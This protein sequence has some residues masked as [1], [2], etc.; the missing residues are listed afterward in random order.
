M[1]GAA[2]GGR[3][4]PRGPPGRGASA[5]LAKAVGAFRTDAAPPAR[6]RAGDGAP[7]LQKRFA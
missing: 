1:E 3:G 7:A 2:G 6:A 5:A 4:K